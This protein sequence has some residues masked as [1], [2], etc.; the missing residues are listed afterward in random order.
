[1]CVLVMGCTAQEV[2]LTFLRVRLKPVWITHF[3]KLARW[4]TS[5]DCPSWCWFMTLCVNIGNS[6]HFI[7][8]EPSI[9]P[10]CRCSLKRWLDCFMSMATNNHVYW[11]MHPHLFWE[12]PLWMGRFW[13]QTGVFSTESQKVSASPHW[14]TRLKFWIIIWMIIIGKSWLALVRAYLHGIYIVHLANCY[15][16]EY[17]KI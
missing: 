3:V 15:A 4:S 7:S 11:G 16:F 8:A 1:M 9:L 17:P 12:L 13:R 6:L 5:L 10:S 2:W 14:H